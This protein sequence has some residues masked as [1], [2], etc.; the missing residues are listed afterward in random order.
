MRAPSGSAAAADSVAERASSAS[1]PRLR[2]TVNGRFPNRLRLALTTTLPPLLRALLVGLLV[3]LLLFPLLLLVLL[4]LVLVRLLLL[5]R[6][7]VGAG[8]VGWQDGRIAD[9]AM[10]LVG[11]GAVG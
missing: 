1:R 6:A 9:R 4:F 7:E 11:G 2:R 8:P 10:A 3:A 5:R